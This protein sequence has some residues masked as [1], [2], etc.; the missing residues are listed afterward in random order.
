MKRIE[1]DRETQLFV[2]KNI[3]LWWLIMIYSDIRIS[4]GWLY[5][6]EQIIR[7]FMVVSSINIWNS[8]IFTRNK[9]D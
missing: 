5:F 4:N 1:T 6:I 9:Q 7:T 8:I 3:L 2:A